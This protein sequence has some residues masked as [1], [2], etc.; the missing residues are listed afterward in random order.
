MTPN[1]LIWAINIAEAAVILIAGG[2]Y[3]AAWLNL[4]KHGVS[5]DDDLTLNLRGPYRAALA[6][7]A[8]IMFVVIPAL[9]VTYGILY[10]R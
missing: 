1:I 9:L 5:P 10:K 7:A 6:V 3:G 4:R 8:V 2:A